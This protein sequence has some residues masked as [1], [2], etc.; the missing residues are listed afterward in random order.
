MGSFPCC[1]FGLLIYPES[2]GPDFLSV[3]CPLINTALFSTSLHKYAEKKLNLDAVDIV[4]KMN[5]LLNRQQCFP[6]RGRKKIIFESSREVVY[7]S[8]SL[9]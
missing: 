3:L 7:M 2:W 4:F 1:L 6:F 8:E 9:P 5:S